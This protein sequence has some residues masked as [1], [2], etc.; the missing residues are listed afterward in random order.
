[1]L[2]QRLQEIEPVWLHETQG[3]L[4]Q[5]FAGIPAYVDAASRTVRRADTNARAGPSFGWGIGKFN[6]RGKSRV[7]ELPGDCLCQRMP[8]GEDF[9]RSM[10]GAT[11]FRIRADLRIYVCQEVS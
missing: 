2:D 5:R 9:F 8:R 1:M 4:G 11:S 3:S 7:L 6:V 10:R